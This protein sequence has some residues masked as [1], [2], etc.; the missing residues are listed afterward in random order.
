M[1]TKWTNAWCVATGLAAMTVAANVAAEDARGIHVTGFAEVLVEPDMAHI[2]FEIVRQGQDAKALSQEVDDVTA[3]VVKL[4]ESV[5]VARKDITTAVVQVT[6]EYRMNA[7]R[8]ILDGVSVRRTVRVE[9]SDLAR[10]EALLEGALEAG[11]NTISGIEL[12]LSD[13]DTLE[14]EAVKAAI[15]DAIREAGF[16][17]GELGIR[18][19]RVIDVVVHDTGPA[20]RPM[21]MARMAAEDS[22]FRPGQIAVSR[23]VSVLFEIGG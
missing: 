4:A 1:M 13:R 7:G 20:F 22:S 23:T 18:V 10:Y 9:L 19:G 15:E 5:K 6:P 14:R 2:T 11:V 17:A 12:D 3:A 16:A 21:A 8:S